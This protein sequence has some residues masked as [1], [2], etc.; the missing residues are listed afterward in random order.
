MADILSRFSRKGRAVLILLL[1]GLSA[2]AFAGVWGVVQN[3][4][5]AG[6]LASAQVIALGVSSLVCLWVSVNVTSALLAPGAVYVKADRV[7]VVGLFCRAVPVVGITGFRTEPA[8][9]PAFRSNV[10]LIVEC[11]GGAP[12][13]IHSGLNTASLDEIQRSLA[14]RRLA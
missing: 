3:L 13:R 1:V 2:I 12:I 14:I 11:G 5:G 9:T 10:D 7:F 6:R 8:P 4:T